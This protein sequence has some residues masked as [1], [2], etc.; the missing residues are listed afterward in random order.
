MGLSLNRRDTT[1]GITEFSQLQAR[2]QGHTPYQ[3]PSSSDPAHITPHHT[4]EFCNLG[5]PPSLQDFSSRQISQCESFE[6]YGNRAL[7]T[8]DF[9]IK[10]EQGSNSS[11]AVFIVTIGNLLYLCGPQFC[12]SIRWE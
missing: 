7:E 4:A 6:S 9:V 10:K 11:L 3:A 12:F 8:M 5:L 1:L 2:E